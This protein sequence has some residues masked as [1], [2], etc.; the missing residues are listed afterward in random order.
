[1]NMSLISV[2]MSTYREPVTY[3]EPAVRSILNQTHRQLELIIVLDD[4]QNTQ[5]EALIRQLAEE[6]SRVKVL[7]NETNLGL[8]DSLNKALK[9]AGGEYIARMDADDISYPNRLEEELHY[10]QEH[11]LDMVGSMIRKIDE[12]GRQLPT[13]PQRHYSPEQISRR[14]MLTACLPHPTWLVR[15]EVYETLGVYRQMPRCEDYDFML[16]AVKKGYRLG[17]CDA[18]LLEYRCNAAGI[19]QSGLL[20][21]RLVGR[22]LADHLDRLEE[23]TRQEIDEMLKRCLTKQEEKKYAD[24]D[25]LLRQATVVRK[26]A[27]IRAGFLVIKSM[28]KSKYY[29]KKIINMVKLKLMD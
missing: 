25:A 21:Q 11:G 19:S 10:L 13:A 7:K 3:I 12:S 2:L 4:P 6:D 26:T 9:H 29:R 27:P 28:T 8:V 15:R 23:I 5:A 17:L 24:A 18:V 22:Y 16:R 1:M 14:L 20:E